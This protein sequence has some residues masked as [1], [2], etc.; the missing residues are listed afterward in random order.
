MH[1]LVIIPLHC[2]YIRVFIS[3]IVNIISM[4]TEICLFALH[5]II[6]VSTH[7]REIF[8]CIF[9]DFFCHCIHPC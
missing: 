1:L 3:K 6:L 7:S 5:D 8:S 9:T 4:F 2:H